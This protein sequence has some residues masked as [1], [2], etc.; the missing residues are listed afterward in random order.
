MRKPTPKE[1][2]KALGFDPRDLLSIAEAL[3]AG[4]AALVLHEEIEDLSMK[5]DIDRWEIGSRRLRA[6]GLLGVFQRGAN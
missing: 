1:R 3:E 6:H 4:K 2:I 5:D